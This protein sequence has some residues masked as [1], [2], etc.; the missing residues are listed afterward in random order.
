MPISPRTIWPALILAASRNDR[1]RGR[2]V[3]LV[4]SI[5]TRNGL[6][7]SGAPSG[8]KCAI[9]FLIDLKNLDIIIASQSGS[10]KIKVKIRCLDVLKK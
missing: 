8:K 4:V 7:Q 2:T 6:S 5:N 3:T 10:P 1:V 9:D